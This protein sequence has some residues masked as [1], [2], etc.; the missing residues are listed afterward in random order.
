MHSVIRFEDD[1]R[2]DLEQFGHCSSLKAVSAPAEI[3]STLAPEIFLGCNIAVSDLLAAAS[4]ADQ[5]WYYWSI[6]THQKC[7]RQAKGTIFTLMLLNQR[8]A[9]AEDSNTN[10]FP[11]AL[12]QELWFL[13]LSMAPRH[14][15]CCTRTQE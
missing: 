11:L 5:L 8:F 7:S 14:E 4:P 10:E 12:P 6:S 1:N 15:L 3:G 2:S 9:N 13:I